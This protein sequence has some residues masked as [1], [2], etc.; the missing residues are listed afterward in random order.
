MADQHSDMRREILEIPSAV[1]RLLADGADACRSAVADE[2]AG[3]G[4]EVFI[5]SGK[6]AAARQLAHV[7]SAHPLADPLSLIV[8]FYAMVERIATERGINPDTPR[9]LKKVTQTT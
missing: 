9:H 3:K 2:L 4:A 7:R 1:E 8:S 5:T 6:S